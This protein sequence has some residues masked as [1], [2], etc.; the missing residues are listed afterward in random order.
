MKSIR[1]KYIYISLVLLMNTVFADN[2]GVVGKTYPIS[3]PD[4]IEWIK[5]KAA[6]LM[7]SGEWQKIQNKAIDNA[8]QQINYPKAIAG[9]SDATV[10][11]TWY[12]TPIVTLN[13]NL[14]D[15]R[16]HVIAKA[17][18]YNAL[19]YKPFDTQMIFINGN[20]Q[21]QVDWALT[22]NNESGIK[23]KIILTQGSFMDLDKKYKVWFYY[24]Q[25]GK[26][27]Q[28]LNIKHVPAIVTQSGDQ[29]KIT[30]ISNTEI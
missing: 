29:L 15:G 30:E 23:T 5:A 10:T 9:I 2:L 1:H 28:K 12:F 19:R 6:A 26:Y 21:K 11:K 3:E 24:D 27:T 18:K 8:K 13:E 7:K 20:N 25:N 22:R 16:G 17:G 4:M 14:T